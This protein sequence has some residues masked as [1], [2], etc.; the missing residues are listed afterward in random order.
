MAASHPPLLAGGAQM[1]HKHVGH[2]GDDLVQFSG[3][4][5]TGVGI[6]D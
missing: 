2:V 4:E 3:S 1:K 6:A 5:M